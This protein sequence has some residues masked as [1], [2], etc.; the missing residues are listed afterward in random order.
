MWVLWQR[1]YLE[2]KCL[3]SIQH[4]SPTSSDTPKDFYLK[5]SGG[6]LKLSRTHSYYYQVQGQ[7]ALC[8]RKYTYFMCWTPYGL[9]LEQIEQDLQ[10]SHPLEQQVRLYL[11]RSGRVCW[12]N[13]QEKLLRISVSPCLPKNKNSCIATAKEKKSTTTWLNV[14]THLVY[15][16]GITSRVNVVTPPTGQ[17]YCDDCSNSM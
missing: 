10:H 7:M 8:D 6:T 17:W 3:Y 16:G 12:F 4:I 5:P 15:M 9:H 14:K 13:W 1:F 2:V 11:E